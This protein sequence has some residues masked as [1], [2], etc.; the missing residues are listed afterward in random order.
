[1]DKPLSTLTKILLGLWALVTIPGGLLLLFVPSFANSIVWPAPLEPIPVIHAMF[2]GA[3]GIG[4]GVASVLALWQNRWAGAMP[5][6]GLYVVYAIFAEYTAITNIL[7]GPVPLQI[8][9]Y[10][11]LGAFYLVTSFIVWR[12]KS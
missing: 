7:R 2:N 5:M 9:F 11:I 3:I 12:Q 1:M 10:V 4:T 6:L 8:W